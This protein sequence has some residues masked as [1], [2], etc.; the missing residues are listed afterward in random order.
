MWIASSS[1]LY[2]DEAVESGKAMVWLADPR[3]WLDVWRTLINDAWSRPM[4]WIAAMP[5]L[6]ALFFTR[7]RIRARIVE[8][9][10]QAARGSC[11]RFFPTV[12][13]VAMTVFSA[14]GMAG[15]RVLVRMA[16]GPSRTWPAIS[17][18]PSGAGLVIA[19]G[20]FFA[21]RLL[22]R[23]CCN[24]GLGEA[25]FGWSVSSLKLMR[26][27]LRWLTLVVLPLAFVAVVM[28][29]Q[30]NVN[31]DNSLGRICFVGALAAFALFTQ[32]VLR[33]TGSVFQSLITYRQNGWLDRFR[34]VWYP[35]VVLIPASLA[36]LAAAGYYYTAQHLAVRLAVTLCLLM[37]LILLRAVLLRW[38]LVNK[39]Q[40]GH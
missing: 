23:T 7:G 29:S 33:P 25:H 11:Y 37:G 24:K 28:G 2:T 34:Y 9:G 12:E 38:I 32:R 39:R 27:N 14:T 20:V 31:W 35:A 6:F 5:L 10:E 40:L 26:R 30:E 13:T 21:Q 36:V 22:W 16:V 17:P 3:N 18:R 15:D 19:S 1:P 4:L 8:T